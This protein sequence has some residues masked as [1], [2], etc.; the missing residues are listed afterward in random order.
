MAST[1]SSSSSNGFT[2]KRTAESVL[3][4]LLYDVGQTER[5]AE[6]RRVLACVKINPFEILDIQDVE[7]TQKQIS[8][9]YRMMSIKTHPD[10]CAP[11]LRGM[12]EKASA[13]IND[14]KSKF[15]DEEYMDQIK[16]SIHKTRQ[17]LIDAKLKDISDAER[18]HENKRRKLMG[19]K[20]LD[21]EEEE[22][23][24]AEEEELRMQERQKRADLEAKIGKKAAKDRMQK[25]R[26][27][28]DKKEAQKIS[29]PDVQKM[30]RE[31]QDA[32]FKEFSLG[33]ADVFKELREVLIEQE[34]QKRQYL[35][36]AAK[37]EHKVQGK[38]SEKKVYANKLQVAKKAW[39]DNRD[40][41]VASW[42]DYKFR[43]KKKKKRKRFGASG[44][45][46]APKFS[47]QMSQYTSESSFGVNG[48][49][50]GWESAVT[51][52]D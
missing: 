19:L 25:A 36:V 14:A 43:E 35:K 9:A 4:D 20:T 7:A 21:E 38:V 46:A 23:K 31:E 45:P 48:K 39:E 26:E 30:T 47:S 29:Q 40:T 51:R 34:W 1:A 3:G 5:E 24:K 37:I 42:R 22:A 44:M 8:R 27:K 15:D 50:G 32:K 33:A 11:D 41:R 52:N 2:V 28:E 16:R 18:K 6:I 13:I 12:A 10:K 49:R 17:R